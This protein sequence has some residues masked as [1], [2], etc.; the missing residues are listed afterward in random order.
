MSDAPTWI[1]LARD[2]TDSVIV[3]G[4]RRTALAA[5]LDA[6]TGLVVNVSPGTSIE[7]V[8]RRAL[9][10]AL[11]TPAP[12]L[13]KAVPQRL[14]VPAELFQATQAAAGHLSWLADTAVTEGA[15]MVDAEEIMDNLV[16]HLEGRAQPDDLPAADDYRVLYRELR[17]YVEAEP[18]K[19]WTDSDWFT[20]RL[21]LD[22]NQVELDCVVLGN[23][24]VQH[25]FNA[26]PDAEQ[27]LT[28]S[29]SRPNDSLRHLDGALIVHLDPWRQTPGRFADKARRYGWPSTNTLAP[30]LTSV[31]GGQPSD[32]S[33]TEVRVLALA[34]RGVLS[35]DARRLVT[36]DK[37][38]VTGELT[39]ADATVGR[40][41]ITRP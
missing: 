30:S 15:G 18:W 1:V 4:Q 34:L 33:R 3:G 13:A 28:A 14:V 26:L 9:K 10:S 36:A 12:P 25:G 23:A 29:T 2:V 6:E 40:Y 31:H 21:D 7:G 35:Q 27:L 41:D 5:V 16:G 32:M 38:A 19:R 8:L 39:F 11:V 17:A 37:P 22:G 20:A 24:G